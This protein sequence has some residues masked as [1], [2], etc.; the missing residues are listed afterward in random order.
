MG[1]LRSTRKSRTYAL[2]QKHNN[3][4]GLTMLEVLGELTGKRIPRHSH[5]DPN[6]RP[7]AGTNF[8]AKYE[9]NTIVTAC[10]TRAVSI[11]G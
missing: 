6:R 2:K 1:Y 11:F 3:A 4:F 9:E 8:L 5:N 10:T 7:Q